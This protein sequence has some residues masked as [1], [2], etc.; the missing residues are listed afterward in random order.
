[1][2]L[3]FVYGTLK[4]HGSNH[5]FLAGQQFVGEARTIPGYVLYSLGDYP[6]M[7]RSSDPTHFVTGEVWQVDP[8]GMA[9]LDKLE[10]THEGLYDRV[11]ISL[12]SPFEASSVE[13]Y[14]YLRTVEGRSVVGSTWQI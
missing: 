13:T 8:T 7:I 10:G 5:R 2:K 11:S 6:G 12:E 9:E 14:L 4:R 3:I 1:M